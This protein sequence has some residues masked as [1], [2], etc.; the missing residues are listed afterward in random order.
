MRQS[1]FL[2]I[3][4]A[5]FGEQPKSAV[6]TVFGHPGICASPSR[7][8]EEALQLEGLEYSAYTYERTIETLEGCEPKYHLF[9]DAEAEHVSWSDGSKATFRKLDGSNAVSPES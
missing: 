8:D 6:Y 3:A 5:D 9:L 2:K 4:D 1:R 7:R